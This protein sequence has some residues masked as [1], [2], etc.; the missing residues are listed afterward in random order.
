MNSILQG[1]TPSLAIKIRA[2][3]FLVT[4]VIKLE[5]TFKHSGTQTIKHLSDVDTDIENNRFIYRFTEQETLALT[6]NKPFRYQL[7]FMLPGNTIVGTQEMTL[8]IHDLFS[9]EVMSE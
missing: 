8:D 9:T 4:D 5:L 7:R 1:T 3:D 6:P 2:D